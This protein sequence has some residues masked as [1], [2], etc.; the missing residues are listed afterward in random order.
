ML[1]P[2]DDL[3]ERVAR[4]VRED[5][6]VRVPGALGFDAYRAIARRLGVIVGEERIALRSGA[7]AYVAK[8]GPVPLHTDQPEVDVIGWY[9]DRQDDADGATLLFDMKPFVDRLPLDLRTR[10]FDV[11]LLTPP[12]TGGPPTMAWPVLRRRGSGVAVFCSP[13]LRSA[14]PIPEHV[15]A[16]ETFRAELSRAITNERVAVRLAAGEA[17]FVD[18]GRVLH[19]RGA[20]APDS[21]RSLRRLWI[22]AAPMRFVAQQS[23]VTG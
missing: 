16:L 9:C 22:S 19:G 23:T 13:W 14:S 18:N 21:Q 4:L 1:S 5:G 3:F 15:A 17:L 2:S 20:I 6:Y 8:P 11:R 10:L 12:V 7:H